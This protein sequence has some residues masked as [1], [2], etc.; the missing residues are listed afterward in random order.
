MLTVALFGAAGK[1]GGRIASK[2]RHHPDYRLVCVEEGDA[3]RAHLRAQG[4]DP[5]PWQEAARRAD[6]ALLALPDVLV[7][8]L[9]QEIVP[10]LPT[11]ALV[12]CL[13]PAAPYAGRLPTRADVAC[14]VTHPAHPP[15][16]G[17]PSDTPDGPRDFF[18]G[19]RAKQAI[20]SALVRGTEDDYAR[21]EAL[22]RVI[23]GPILRSHRVTLEQMAILEPVLSETV[24]ATCLTIIREALE[25]A[26]VRGVP[27]DAARDF[28]MG[29]INV[30]IAILFGE[31]E[32]RLSDGALLAVEEGRRDL[33]RPDWK[34]VFEREHLRRSVESITADPQ[35]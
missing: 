23:F 4:L 1:M 18:G 11:G 6:I 30:E 10:L 8:R 25:E 33:F 26:V 17:D 5:T 13:D 3:G 31:I 27:A 16:F 21:G 34:R 15:L 22:A 28:V 32:G 29:H 14:F 12:M 19:V 7:G 2:L 20:V 24:T 35:G 9:T